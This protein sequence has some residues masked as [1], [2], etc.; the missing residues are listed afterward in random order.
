MKV[1]P[2]SVHC[3]SWTWWPAASTVAMVAVV[4]LAGGMPGPQSVALPLLAVLVFPAALLLLTGWAC[5]L[6]LLR[7]PH[8]AFSALLAI[9]VPALLVIPICLIQPY[10][11]L[12]LTLTFG[13]GYLGRAPDEKQPVA[14]YD[15]STGLTGGPD[16]FLIHD[17][18]DAVAL[19]EPK[20]DL[21]AWKNTDF[22]RDCSGKSQHLIGHY[23]VCVIE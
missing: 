14:V 3:D 13:I 16:T 19:P 2:P 7:R 12:A 21:S 5:A 4:V 20:G 15:W 8:K 23:Y 10:V 6:F 17:M 11:H 9:A 18:T 1:A 22:L